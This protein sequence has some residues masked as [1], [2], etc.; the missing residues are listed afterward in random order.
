MADTT[1]STTDNSA[2]IAQILSMLQTSSKSGTPPTAPNQATNSQGQAFQLGAN[3]LPTAENPGSSPTASLF[4]SA[5][6]TSL[7]TSGMSDEALQNWYASNQGKSVFGSDGNMVQIPSMSSGSSNQGNQYGMSAPSQGGSPEPGT[8]RAWMNAGQNGGP[9]GVLNGASLTNPQ[10]AQFNQLLQQLQNSQSTPVPAPVTAPIAPPAIAPVAN[11]QAAYT[12]PSQARI[13]GMGVKAPVATPGVLPS[14][15][16]APPPPS[17]LPGLTTTSNAL[18]A[19]AAAGQIT[20]QTVPPTM[21]PALADK[22]GQGTIQPSDITGAGGP[23]QASTSNGITQGSL[24]PQVQAPAVQPTPSR[25]YST[26]PFSAPDANTQI[27]L[28]SNTPGASGMIGNISGVSGAQVPAGNVT[29]VTGSTG[30]VSM[31]SGI[32]GASGYVADVPGVSASQAAASANTPNGGG[33]TPGMG[34]ALASG[35]GKIGSA[36]A[37][38]YAP[39]P[40][41]NL[42]TLQQTQEAQPKPLVFTSPR[43][44]G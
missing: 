41:K 16:Q 35:I 39:I 43:M 44:V 5:T 25:S 21:A 2:L 3:G 4:D 28:P 42:P 19:K 36:I 24:P 40:L 11:N 22:L 31:P 7:P 18:Q 12:D 6:A 29:P 26:N 9:S 27:T 20:P 15:A 8:I 34:S 14:V 13:P 1:A 17:T 38:A 33:M 32:D 37:G 23:L 10:S 30:Q